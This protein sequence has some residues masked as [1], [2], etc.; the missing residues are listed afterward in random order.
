LAKRLVSALLLGLLPFCAGAAWQHAITM[1]GESKY[2]PEFQHFDYVNP[3]APKGGRLRL[4]ATGTYDSLN[5]FILKGTPAG[6]LGLIYDTL[7]AHALDEP[8][9]EYGLIA[10]AIEIAP[11]HKSVKFRLREEARFHDGKPVRPEDVVFSF[12]TLKEKGHPSYRVYWADIVAAEK[13][14]PHEVT[15]SFRTGDNRELP[16]IIGQMPVLPEHYW[17]GRD[18]GKTT[19]EPPV[20]SGPYRVSRVDAG[21]AVTLERVQDYW[22]QD[23]PVN[24]GRYNFDTIRYDY[25]RDGV[26]ALEA[27]KAGAFDVRL[28]NIAKSWATAYDVPAVRDGRLKKIEIPHELPSGMQG[29]FMNLRR[30]LFQDPKVRKALNYAFDF[31][32]TN[33]NIFNG[34]YVR[35]DSFF[36]NS[37]LASEGLPT[38][39]EL[40]LLE[41]F[42]DRLP[43]SVFN[44]P[45]TV[46]NTDGSGIPR[47]NLRIA[48]QLLKEAGWEIQGNRRVNV[49][50]GRPMQFEILLYNPSFERVVLPYV[51]NLERL[52]IGVSVRTVDPTQYQERMKKFDYDMTVAVIGQSL[53]PGNE[54]RGYW[55]CEAAKTEGSRNVAGICDPVVE[56]LIEKL[57]MAPDRETLVAA[58]RALDRVLLAG[59]YVVPHWHT[60]VFRVAYWDKFGRPS[61]PAKYGLPIEDTWWSK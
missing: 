14:G 59:D 32:W 44:E 42:R 37:E 38:G 33:A 21:R 52:G 2:G 12:N 28:E 11:D 49:Q 29:F 41:P 34:A 4:S 53:S 58:T 61:V 23:L 25:Y 35:T 55:G 30:P 47:A 60:N 24:R 40:E 5:P 46:P 26:V 36:D 43:E 17:Q 22:G 48:S 51:R 27:F 50:T 1:H 10:E 57:V 20:G 19:L 18:F 39:K 56:A 15:F 3:D 7:T 8:F 45:Y 31:E 9:S 16:L 13:T 54:Q 6:G